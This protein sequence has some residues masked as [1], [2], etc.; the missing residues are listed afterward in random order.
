MSVT[1]EAVL[2]RGKIVCALLLVLLWY[3]L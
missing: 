1:C 3:F 2:Y